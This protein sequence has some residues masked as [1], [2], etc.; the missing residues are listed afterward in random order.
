MTV[1]TFV[2]IV[3]IMMMFFHC[4]AEINGGEQREDKRLQEGYQQFQQTHEYHE[5]NRENRNTKS[6]TSAH[7]SEDEDETKEGERNDVSGRDVG[8]Q[9]DHQYE[10][11]EEYAE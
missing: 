3:M 2:C 8:E 10:R 11:T 6:K 9:S 1:C 7:F 5:G 4:C